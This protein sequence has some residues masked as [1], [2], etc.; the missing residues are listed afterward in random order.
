MIYEWMLPCVARV[1]VCMNGVGTHRA[2]F[3]GCTSHLLDDVSTNIRNINYLSK[4]L[5]SYFTFIKTFKDNQGHWR[6]LKDIQLLGCIIFALRNQLI[7][8]S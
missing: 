6:T 3:I 1:D 2:A 5:S 7:V 8:G 4:Y